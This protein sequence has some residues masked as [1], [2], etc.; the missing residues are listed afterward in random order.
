MM[1]KIGV[2][3][4]TRWIFLRCLYVLLAGETLC[5]VTYGQEDLK[6]LGL[7]MIF[8]MGLQHLS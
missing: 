6:L 7:L 8:F 1:P 2:F 4:C 5:G 3:A